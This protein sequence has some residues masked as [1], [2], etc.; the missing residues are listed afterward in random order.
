M[1]TTFLIDLFPTRI[2]PSKAV[3]NK[4]SEISDHTVQK[5]IDTPTGKN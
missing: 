4:L 2:G 1:L 3:D 5:S